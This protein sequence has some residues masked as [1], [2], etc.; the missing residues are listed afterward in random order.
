MAMS[1]LPPESD[2]ARTRTQTPSQMPCNLKRSLH[3]ARIQKKKKKGQHHASEHVKHD[4]A[5]IREYI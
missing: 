2:D 3:T 4:K 1:V 5:Q